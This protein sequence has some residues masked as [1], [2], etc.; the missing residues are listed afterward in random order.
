MRICS[1]CNVRELEYRQKYCSECTFIRRE[2]SK[3]LARFNWIKNNP[4]QYKASYLKNNREYRS[5]CVGGR[6]E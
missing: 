2:I 3:D 6:D 5:R 1:D 4:E